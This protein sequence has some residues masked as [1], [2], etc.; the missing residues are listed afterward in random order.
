MR[1]VGPPA[2]VTLQDLV[3]SGGHV[4]DGSAQTQPPGKPGG[5]LVEN[6]SLTAS[7]V[8]FFGNVAGRRGDAPIGG[9]AGGTGGDGGG[10]AGDQRQPVHLRQRRQR[11]RAAARCDRERG[12]GGAISLR[13]GSTLTLLRSTGRHC[14]AG[15]TQALL[16]GNPGPVFGGALVVDGGNATISQSN[17]DRNGSE[18]V[19]GTS[20]G[21]VGGGSLVLRQSSVTRNDEGVAALAAHDATLQLSNAAFAAN[22][23]EGYAI[24]LGY[25][26]TADM[27]FVTVSG[28]PRGS[29]APPPRASSATATA[30]FPATPPV[31][32][33]DRSR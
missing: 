32:A 31:I 10:I 26:A 4:P 17:F 23:N 24:L 20:I 29:T 33:R 8:E 5:I 21:V 16:G 11:R 25:D 6:A 13:N 28:N 18:S 30:S 9:G 1:V 15:I 19:S 3:I 12:T 7:R 27:D 22:G 2:Q 14:R